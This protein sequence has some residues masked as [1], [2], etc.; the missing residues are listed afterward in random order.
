[1]ISVLV[2]DDSALVRRL[3][4][5]VLNETPDI[6]VVGTAVNGQQAL[7]RVEELRPDLL[8]L[9]VE[10]PVMDG[11]A[12]LREL[13]RRHPTLPVIMFSTLTERGAAT[14]LDALA[15]GASDYVTKPSGAGSLAGSLTEI[16]AQLIPRVRA[17]AGRSRARTA[18]ARPAVPRP[19]AP[20]ERARRGR[21]LPAQVVAIG[22]STG[23][24]DALSR[25]LSTLTAR[26]RVPVLVVQH[27]PSVF[28]GMLARRL[29]QV[30][31]ASVVEAED[32]QPLQPGV[33]YVAPGGRHLEVRRR[34]AL[35]V[36]HLNDAEPVNFS[37][38]SVDVLFRSVAATY[39]GAAIAAVL[40]GMGR[41]GRDGCAELAAAGST[42]LAQDEATSVVW[43]MPG[44]VTEAGL[45]D[46]V[47]P[48]GDIGKHISAL[49]DRSLLRPV[50]TEGSP[51]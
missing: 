49:L 37:R 29:D 31:P 47:L 24:P 27:M 44:A 26:P 38:P 6:R 2:A 43:G 10:M 1:M 11:L 28:T 22:S 33:V 16:G 5:G 41:D 20:T 45:A 18:A 51:A 19:G 46:A 23:G 25:L 21:R 3:V 12:A 48:L 36:T 30:G 42:V 14:T 32:G 4:S 17:L 7:D 8:T 9:D 35:A 50:A 40:T 15:A 34:G 39:G 13:R